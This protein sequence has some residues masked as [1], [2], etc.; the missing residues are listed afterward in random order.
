MQSFRYPEFFGVRPFELQAMA[1][2]LAIGGGITVAQI[3]C[4]I[5]QHLFNADMIVKP[6]H[7]AQMRACGCDRQMNR[8]RTM[9]G[10]R[11]A[12]TIGNRGCGEKSRI[13]AAPRR[14][15]LQHI[16]SAGF[17]HAAEVETFI[18]IFARG[19]IYR[20]RSTIAQQSKSFQI[21]ARNRLLEPADPQVSESF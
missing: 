12:E 21:V 16:N 7:V 5:E 20:R 9:A 6:F 14:I 4:A 18:T 1:G 11:Y 13:T 15:D 17:Q 2:T 3:R 10:Y 19:D 8:R